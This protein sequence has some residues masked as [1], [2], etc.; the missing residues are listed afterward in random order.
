MN[1]RAVV[2]VPNFDEEIILSGDDKAVVAVPRNHSHA[3]FVL[4][5]VQARQLIDI[6]P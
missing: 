6:R 4:D 2:G 5:H 3:E 1:Q